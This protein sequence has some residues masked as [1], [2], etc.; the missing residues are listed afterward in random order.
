MTTSTNMTN[1][2]LSVRDHVR[3]FQ[4][5]ILKGNVT[6]LRTAELN[7]MAAALIGN[8]NTALIDAEMSYN[9][10]LQ[11]FYK[12]EKTAN[13]AEVRARAT[14]DYQLWQEA[15]H[16][17]MELLELCR[18]LRKSLDVLREEMRFTPR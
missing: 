5:E 1:H 13:R 8:A 15:K 18:S 16:I 11:S 2:D 9:L 3:Q 7:D 14:K 4:A 10:T 6:P 17:Q 12:D